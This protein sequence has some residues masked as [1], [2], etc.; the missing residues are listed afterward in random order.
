MFQDV[1][2]NGVLDAKEFLLMYRYMVQH[3]FPFM[4]LSRMQL[5]S[6]NIAKMILSVFGCLQQRFEIVTRQMSYAQ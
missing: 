2:Q 5:N 6:G 4:I 1:D 3:Y